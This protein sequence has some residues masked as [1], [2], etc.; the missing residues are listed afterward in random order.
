M[1]ILNKERL[2]STKLLNVDIAEIKT[3]TGKV[4]EHY[5]IEPLRNSVAAVA[6]KNGKII[7]IKTKRLFWDKPCWEIPGGLIQE[8]EIAL[9]AIRRKVEEETGFSVQSIIRLGSTFG[10]IGLNKKEKYYFFIELGEKIQ[11]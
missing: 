11:D 7:M 6:I 4:L 8:G 9:S 1:E 2:L 3:N 5:I 10:D